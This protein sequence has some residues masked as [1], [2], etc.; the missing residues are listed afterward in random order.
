MDTCEAP[1]NSTTGTGTVEPTTKDGAAKPTDITATMTGNKTTGV[2]SPPTSTS[3]AGAVVVS[4]S[5]AGWFI[6]MVLGLASLVAV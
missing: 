5:D 1:G 2:S 6:A 4:N 3:T